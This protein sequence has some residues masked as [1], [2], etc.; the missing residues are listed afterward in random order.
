MYTNSTKTLLERLDA[1]GQ[2]LSTYPAALALIGLGSVGQ[3][4]DRLDEFSDL[5]FFVIVKE[6]SKR[7]FIEDLSWITSVAQTAYSF[8]NTKDGYKLLFTDGVFCEF[9]VFEPNELRQASFAPG[10]VVWKTKG[11][12]DDIAIPNHPPQSNQQKTSEWLLGEALT[13]LYVG[14]LRDKRG[15]HLTANKFIQTYA[16]DRVVD[17]IDIFDP[18]KNSF[19]DA[20]SPDRRFEFRHPQFSKKFNEFMQGYSR[21]KESAVAMLNFLDEH[22]DVD[23]TIKT[24]ILDLSL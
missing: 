17:L 8:A 18:P 9:A 16:L 7:E 3:E 13:N 10:R 12:E 5:D 14:L 4:Q 22:F 23:P 15:E 24:A 11:V 6:G 2:S 19:I 21:N 20:F 1:I